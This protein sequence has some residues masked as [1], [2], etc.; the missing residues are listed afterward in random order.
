M[1]VARPKAEV[2]ILELARAVLKTAVEREG[3]LMRAPLM[4][5]RVT[6]MRLKKLRP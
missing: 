5:I 1:T 3:F 6:V 4:L 2:M